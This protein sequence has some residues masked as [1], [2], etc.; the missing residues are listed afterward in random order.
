M[1]PLAELRDWL[2][3]ATGVVALCAFV[4]GLIQLRL[5]LRN[6]ELQ[7]NLQVIQ[8]E[9][10]VWQLALVNPELAPNILKER[11]GKGVGSERLFACM[12]F[13]HYEALYFQ[14]RRGAIPRA[15]WAGIERAMIEH[16]ASP[17]LRAI[18]DQHKDLY[19]SPFT[20]CIETKLASVYE[21]ARQGSMSARPAPAST[22]A[23]A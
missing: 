19:W 20:H 1:P 14:F 3:V 4:V 12:L 10:S 11:W 13:D 17:T 2:G 15:Y 16:I 5:L 21:R 22:S 9:R 18:W 7:T 6:A 23:P 8:A